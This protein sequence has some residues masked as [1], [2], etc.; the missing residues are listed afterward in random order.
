MN[1]DNSIALFILIGIISAL[2]VGYIVGF[3]V[4]EQFSQKETINFCIEKPAECKTKY[5]YFKLEE[6][7]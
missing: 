5:D 7:K 3:T 6:Q 2:G 4:G 1:D